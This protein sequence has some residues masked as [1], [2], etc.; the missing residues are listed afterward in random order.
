MRCHFTYHL[1]GSVLTWTRYPFRLD[2]KVAV[3]GK[4]H[5]G[6]WDIANAA[7]ITTAQLSSWNPGFNCNALQPGEW[8]PISI[9]WTLVLNIERL[10][11]YLQINA[12]V[13]RLAHFRISLPSRIRMALVLG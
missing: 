8:F 7:K 4:P 11:L 12:C 9:N 2:C 10:C 6:C 5:S 1:H 13:F 3:V